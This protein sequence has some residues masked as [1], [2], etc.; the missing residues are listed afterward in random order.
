MTA[1]PP[2]EPL[3]Q[4]PERAAD[5]H[6]GH[7]GF[8]LIIGGSR[9]MTGAVALAGMAALRGGVGLVRLAVPQSCLDTVAAFEPSYMTFPLPDDP[10]DAN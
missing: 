4:L 1:E 8:A 2:E 9:G 6:K 7:F 3:P 5:S 10:E